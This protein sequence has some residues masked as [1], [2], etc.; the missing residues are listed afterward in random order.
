M[1]P[2]FVVAHRARITKLQTDDEKRCAN[3]VPACRPSRVA[4]DSG[5]GLRLRHGAE[6]L[7]V[8]L[9][10]GRALASR[11]VNRA[12]VFGAVRRGSGSRR[13]DRRSYGG[14][15]DVVRA[16]RRRGKVVAGSYPAHSY[17]RWRSRRRGSLRAGNLARHVAGRDPSGHWPDSAIRHE[18]VDSGRS[19]RP[20]RHFAARV[21]RQSGALKW[22][23]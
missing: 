7:C 10:G 23:S 3:I 16:L 18:L 14:C 1:S 5:V 19:A 8:R 2:A 22:R 17:A 9:N 4:R 6:R 12:R 21:H 11:R 13:R 15:A 20:L